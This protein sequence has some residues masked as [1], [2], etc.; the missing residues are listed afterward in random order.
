[1]RTHHGGRYGQFGFDKQQRKSDEKMLLK[2]CG[3][4]I[5]CNIASGQVGN[6]GFNLTERISLVD[7]LSLYLFEQCRVI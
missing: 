6:Y 2:V 1:M 5:T 4:S 3:I 7:C